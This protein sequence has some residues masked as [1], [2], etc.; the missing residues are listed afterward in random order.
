VTISST[1]AVL[2]TAVETPC[3]AIR[4]WDSF[5]PSQA[6]RCKYLNWVAVPNKHDGKTYRRLMRLPDAAA[7]YGAW[8]ILLAVASKCRDRGVLADQDGPL[9]AEDLAIKT[10]F[11]Q[12][13]L[14]RALEVLSSPEIGWLSVT[15]R[16]PFRVD[17][18]RSPS[19]LGA[20]SESAPNTEPNLTDLTSQNR[21]LQNPTG[22]SGRVLKKISFPEKKDLRSNADVD[23]W[24]RDSGATLGLDP[25][26]WLTRQRV[27]ACA[28]RAIECGDKP[29]G[30]FVSL[31][32]D[33]A[34]GDWSKLTD[35]QMDRGKQRL[36]QLD[37]AAAGRP[38]RPTSADSASTTAEP[39]LLGTVAMTAA[40]LSLASPSK[41]VALP[42]TNG[43]GLAAA[44]RERLAGAHR[45]K[46]SA[47]AAE[48]ASADPQPI[49]R[50]PPR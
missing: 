18:E 38:N 2:K 28:E 5:E 47:I 13:V 40:G 7:I 1:D 34:A 15:T 39:T 43:A 27:V 26:D 48:T 41:T 44:D 36:L 6:K 10:D 12:D 30:L 11:P 20:D 33:G 50:P 45:Q 3:Y 14:Q 23:A 19:T 22:G 9:T 21:T 8:V 42:A 46:Q 49:G 37:R 4:D 24:F 16:S 31:V 35:D 32:R 17:S 25:T 29:R